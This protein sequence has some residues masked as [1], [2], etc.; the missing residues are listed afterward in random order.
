MGI[1]DLGHGL[2]LFHSYSALHFIV[3]MK[4]LNITYIDQHK[5]LNGKWPPLAGINPNFDHVLR[6]VSKKRR[7][8]SSNVLTK[9]D[10]FVGR[11]AHSA[12]LLEPK[13]IHINILQFRHEDFLIMAL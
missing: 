2:N 12:V 4:N 5:R 8:Y 6:V 3:F 9:I 1:R 7:I 13:F 11:M 10:C